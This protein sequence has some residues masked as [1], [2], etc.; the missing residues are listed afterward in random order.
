MFGIATHFDYSN[1][2]GYE[3]RVTAGSDG[4][5]LLLRIDENWVERIREWGPTVPGV[6]LSDP[7]LQLE[8]ELRVC[9]GD[10]EFRVW[11]VNQVRPAAMVSFYDTTYRSGMSAFTFAHWPQDPHG[12]RM[13]SY[14]LSEIDPDLTPFI[15]GDTN[16][17][18]NLDI[19]DAISILS[20]LF[21]AGPA[22][23]CEDAADANDDG[24]VDIADAIAV[25]S[26]LFGG[27]GDLPEPFGECGEDPTEDELG[28]N[29]YR[30][31]EDR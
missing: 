23:S 30:P 14:C 24:A 2:C 31:C 28:C 5:L 22:P 7:D 25:L 11:E 3:G 27:A 12:F 4:R 13:Y 18:S 15:R 17:D 1:V 21:A 10:V 26:H 20:F 16:G 9:G 29:S 6:D 8:M 19:A